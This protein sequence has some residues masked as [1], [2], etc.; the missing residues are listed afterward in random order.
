MWGLSFK[1]SVFLVFLIS[2]FILETLIQ[3]FGNKSFCPGT[4]G[5]GEGKIVEEV[6]AYAST[7]LTLAGIIFAGISLILSNALSDIYTAQV[8]EMSH[9]EVY[10]GGGFL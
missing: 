6:K 7:S 2:G 8:Q 5:E 9:F 1:A 3:L 4:F 10:K